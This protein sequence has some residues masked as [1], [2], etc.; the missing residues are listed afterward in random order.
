[1]GAPRISFGPNLIDY[2]TVV[3][4]LLCG[5]AGDGWAR[6]YGPIRTAGSCLIFGVITIRQRIE[7]RDFF[8]SVL[9]VGNLCGLSFSGWRFSLAGEVACARDE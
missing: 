9:R 2:K 4:L 3:H 5:C 1:M 8:Y 6:V 7:E